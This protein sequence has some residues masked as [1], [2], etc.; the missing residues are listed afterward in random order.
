MCVC[1]RRCACMHTH[2]YAFMC[3]C[4]HMCT[5]HTSVWHCVPIFAFVWM[6]V[7]CSYMRTYMFICV[8]VCAL[9]YINLW[10]YMCFCV[11]VCRECGCV[12]MHTCVC[13][14]LGCNA[15]TWGISTHGTWE[16]TDVYWIFMAIGFINY[17]AVSSDTSWR[18]G[19]ESE[20]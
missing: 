3:E 5:L 7:L 13:G 10:V 16:I 1:V 20:S 8:L 9:V 15:S 6:Y 17:K 14:E 18:T 11:Y 2:V 19:T 4:L 12:C